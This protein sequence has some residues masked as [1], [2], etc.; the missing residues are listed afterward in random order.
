VQDV[1][2]ATAAPAPASPPLTADQA[3]SVATQASG[4]RVVE[5]KEDNEPTGLRY[6]VTLLHEDGTATK[7]EVDA[8][9][10]RIVSTELQDDSDG[11]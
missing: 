4:G 8:A 11:R 2:A 1:P 3:A 5:L 6:D 10:G 9:T 7:I